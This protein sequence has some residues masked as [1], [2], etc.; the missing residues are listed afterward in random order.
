MTLNYNL[1]SPA[2]YSGGLDNGALQVGSN[3]GQV[4]Y[5]NG[6]SWN[7]P[8]GD[9]TNDGVSPLTPFRSITHAVSVC[10]D[11]QM[12]TIVVLDHWQPDTEVW[13]IVVDKSCTTVVGYAG[14]SYNRWVAVQTDENT[15]CFSIEADAVRIKD[16]YLAAGAAHPCIEFSGAKSRCGIYGCTFAAGTHGVEWGVNEA[17]FGIEIADCVF[18]APLTAGGISASNSPYCM[19]RNNVFVQ[20]QGVCI[21]AN[22]SGFSYSMIL[23][24]VMS[25]DSDVAGRAITLIVGSAHNVIDGNSAQ[26]G[27]AIG[28]N[29]YLDNAGAN[30]N[31]WGMN[32]HGNTHTLPG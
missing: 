1:K 13:P 5:V 4:W 19:F 29:P 20:P 27:E 14:G 28:N 23:N 30:A 9:D 18:L 32:H 12:D 8:V 26:F 16:L 15:A 2:F 25:I 6:A 21:E 11:D 3:K 24:N 22:H 7:A 31:C 17:G 10:N